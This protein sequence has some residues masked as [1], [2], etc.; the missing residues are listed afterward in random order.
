MLGKI[1]TILFLAHTVLFAVQNTERREL[2]WVFRSAC[3][4]ASFPLYRSGSRRWLRKSQKANSLALAL[5][6]HISN[7][8]HS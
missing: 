3:C 6:L 8:L 5:V 4:A 2:F 7:L 1:D